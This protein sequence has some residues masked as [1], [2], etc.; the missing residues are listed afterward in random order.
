[1]TRLVLALAVVIVAGACD[2]G[3][4][5]RRATAEEIGSEL[6]D[7]PLREDEAPDGLEPSERGTGPITSIREVLPP[8]T[9]L[10]N[11]PPIPPVIREGFDGGYQVVYLR[12]EGESGP[13]S[14]ASSALRFGGED[15]ARAFLAYFREVQVGAGRGQ[16]REEITVA[17][18][19]DGAFGWHLEEPLAESSTVAWR[20][21]DLVLTVTVS[22]R[23]GSADPERAVTLARTVERRLG[24]SPG[25]G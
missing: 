5:D 10:P 23:I 15:S 22:G 25:G 1:V 6:E 14:A 9:S 18:V 20:S 8:R 16:E 12:A 2:G 3:E 19:G 21:G 17:G 11:L 24:P 4:A 7:A 13:A